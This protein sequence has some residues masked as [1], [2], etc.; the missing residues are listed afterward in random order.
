MKNEI[1]EAKLFFMER[2]IQA[3]FNDN[4]ILLILDNEDPLSLIT[5]MKFPKPEHLNLIMS[6]AWRI[7]GGQR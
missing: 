7:F 2:A 1:E 3:G 6:H 5:Y 4:H